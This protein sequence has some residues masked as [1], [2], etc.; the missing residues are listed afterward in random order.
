MCASAFSLRDTYSAEQ[1]S[2][3]SGI[4]RHAEHW[5][6]RPTKLRIR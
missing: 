3:L 1:D 4:I 2:I 6:L 5:E